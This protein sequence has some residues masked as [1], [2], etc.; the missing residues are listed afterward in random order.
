MPR[1]IALRARQPIRAH[2]ITSVSTNPRERRMVRHRLGFALTIIVFIA[3]LAKAEDAKP[4]PDAKFAAVMKM[5]KRQR[6]EW[7]WA[8]V[9]WLIQ[10]SAAQKISASEG[11]PIL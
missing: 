11:K 6:G 4:V 7:L 10:F 2:K 5:I 9:P 3:A 8:D 1:E